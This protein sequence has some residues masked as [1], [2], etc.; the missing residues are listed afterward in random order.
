MKKSMWKQLK[1]T[2][3]VSEQTSEFAELSVKVTPGTGSSSSF[4]VMVATQ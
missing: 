3:K 4:T 1:M 2:V